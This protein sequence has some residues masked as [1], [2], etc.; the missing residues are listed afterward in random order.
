[1]YVRQNKE[2]MLRVMQA[3]DRANGFAYSG[4]ET[5]QSLLSFMRSS[6]AAEFEYD[7]IGIIQEQ[8][9]RSE[10]QPAMDVDHG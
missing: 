7:K 4:S 10:T 8:Y 2:T 5:D 9:V 1:M 6:T 3:V